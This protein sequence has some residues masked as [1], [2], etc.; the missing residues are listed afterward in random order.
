LCT[1]FNRFTYR[2]KKLS[3]SLFFVRRH[4]DS[5]VDMRNKHLSYYPEYAVGV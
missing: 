4:P 3:V 2:D 5:D 1:S